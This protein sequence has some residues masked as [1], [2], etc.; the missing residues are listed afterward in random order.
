MA[1]H[2]P[3]QTNIHLSDLLGKLSDPGGQQPQRDPGGLQHRLLTDVRT[4]ARLGEP[5]TGTE[6]FGI[7]QA[8]QLFPQSGISDDEDGLE[9][10]RL[11][12]GYNRRRLRELVHSRD[13]HRPVARFGPCA[14]PSAQYGALRVLC[15]E[16]I[17]FAAPTAIRPVHPV[18]IKHVHPWASR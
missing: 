9:L 7:A 18:H 12:A 8:G 4:T 3:G 13:L 1:F 14:G 6:G 15:I 2:Q 11:G 5:R 10:V 16:R 17:C